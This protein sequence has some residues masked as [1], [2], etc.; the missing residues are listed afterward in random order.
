[1]VRDG[2]GDTMAIPAGP[3]GEEMPP[4]EAGAPGPGGQPALALRRAAEA[5]EVRDCGAWHGA[6]H[7]LTCDG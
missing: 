2:R 6:E 1:M 5:N 3:S 7:P 4:G